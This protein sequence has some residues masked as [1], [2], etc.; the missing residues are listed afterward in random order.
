MPKYRIGTRYLHIQHA[1]GFASHI[2]S[3]FVYTGGPDKSV[4]NYPKVYHHLLYSE[5]L[6]GRNLWQIHMELDYA[7]SEVNIIARSICY[8]ESRETEYG[9]Y[10]ISADPPMVRR[11]CYEYV[12]LQKRGLHLCGFPRAK[13]KRKSTR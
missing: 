12:H 6:K 9:P 2:R 8:D 4:T 11:I 5:D 3:N 10:L 1:V 7:I 13:V